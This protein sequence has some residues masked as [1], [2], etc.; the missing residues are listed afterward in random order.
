MFYWPGNSPGKSTKTNPQHGQGSGRPGNGLQQIEQNGEARGCGLWG[1]REAEMEWGDARWAAKLGQKPGQQNW[2]PGDTVA[3]AAGHPLPRPLPGITSRVQLH[4]PSSPPTSGRVPVVLPL[5]AVEG[6][7]HTWLW[8]RAPRPRRRLGC[9]AT[10]AHGTLDPSVPVRGG[11]CG[12]SPQPESAW[13][14]GLRTG[15]RVKRP[16]KKDGAS[17]HGK[18]LRN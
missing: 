5:P 18:M 8:G 11:R 15:L 1:S 9:S 12:S 4:P 10:E 16:R 3:I 13:P 6:H 2:P 17:C 14:E 7:T